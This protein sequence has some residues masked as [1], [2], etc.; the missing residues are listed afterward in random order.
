MLASHGELT[1]LPNK[2]LILSQDLTG[3]GENVPEQIQPSG[4]KKGNHMQKDHDY[5]YFIVN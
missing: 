2:G 5:L 1:A 4:G 3:K